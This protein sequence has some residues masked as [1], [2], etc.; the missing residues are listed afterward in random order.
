M[1]SVSVCGRPRRSRSARSGIPVISARIAALALLAH[2]LVVAH[3]VSHLAPPA[4]DSASQ[5]CVVCTLGEHSAGISTAAVASS[6]HMPAWVLE[7]A[8]PPVAPALRAAGAILAR[9]PPFQ[10]LFPIG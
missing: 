3:T 4:P 9:G 5:K 7:L 1:L 10:A 6:P 8:S 2:L